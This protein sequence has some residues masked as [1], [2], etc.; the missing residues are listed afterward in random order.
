MKTFRSAAFA[1]II[2]S[3]SALG[4]VIEEPI[5][6]PKQ[7]QEADFAGIVEV[8]KIVETGHKK[9]LYKG[10]V[11]FRELALEL[12]VLSP[13]KGKGDTITCS[14]YREPTEEELLAD[15]LAKNE[16]FK[17]LLN[18]GTNEMLHLFP[19]R[20][21]LGVQLLAYLRFE[22]SN[23]YPV[24]GD[25][26]SSRS[27]LRLDPSN[28]VNTL[29]HVPSLP[30]HTTNQDFPSVDPFSDVADVSA[31]TPRTGDVRIT[32]KFVEIYSGTEELS[33]DWIVP[34]QQSTPNE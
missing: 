16:V 32:T 8:T 3:S 23:L 1:L 14:I 17:T 7:L 20:V 13:F 24:A 11:A 30:K 27:L 15:G 4:W 34:F 28:M 12:K 18:L 6:Y 29:S 21:T 2:A 9:I 26:N 25:L 31:L 5:D 22:G 33:F 19:A 10:S